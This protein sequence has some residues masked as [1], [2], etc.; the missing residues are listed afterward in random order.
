MTEQD[1]ALSRPL[2]V[3]HKR[4][5][6]SCYDREA[7]RELIEASMQPGVSVAGMALRHG[8][9][10]N[11][12]RTWIRRYQLEG[13]ERQAGGQEAR[14]ARDVGELR[15][16]AHGEAGVRPEEPQPLGGEVAD[17]HTLAAIAVQVGGV[18]PH[19]RAGAARGAVGDAHLHGDLL[20][21][22]V[23]EVPVEEVWLQVV[24]QQQVG[25]QFRRAI[26]RREPPVHQV[27]FAELIYHDLR[28]FQIPVDDAAGVGVG[29]CLGH[30]QENAQLPLEEVL[31]IE[32]VP[33]LVHARS[34]V[35]P[36]NELHHHEVSAQVIGHDRNEMQFLAHSTFE[37]RD[38]ERKCAVAGK[39]NHRS[40]RIGQPGRHGAS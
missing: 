18:Q 8:I 33:L 11:L 15:A 38:I 30:R 5:G 25:T 7:K 36:S 26:G 34:P 14:G 24:G 28:G 23:F 10:A 35:G 16:V 22:A 20:E 6:R 37:L 12:L 29:G 9:N 17:E 32:A 3:G 21:G 31:R 13:E 19:P 4:D 27:G 1:T 39:Q 2:V 40:L